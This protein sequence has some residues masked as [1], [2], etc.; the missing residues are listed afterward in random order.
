MPDIAGLGTQALLITFA[1]AAIV[2]ALFGTQMAR[3][4]DILADRTGLGEALVGAVLLGAGT[5]ISG[6]V[7]SISTA[8]NGAPELAASNALGGI[9][10]QTMFLALADVFYRKVNL[11][12]AAASAV[13]LGQATILII[14]TVLPIMAVMTPEFSIWAIHPV[15]PVL[16]AVY[17]IGLHNAHRIKLEPMWQPRQTEH[18]R[19]EDEEEEQDARSTFMLASSFGGLLL[20]VGICGYVVGESGLELSGRLG[21]SQG[22]VG[23]LGT[24]VV[25]SL[26]E[27]VTTIAA[28]R[29]GALQLAIGGIIGGNMFDALF[30]SASD[31][32]YREG[33]LYHALSDRVVFWMAL[34]GLMTAILLMG[35]LRRERQ[36]PAGIGWESVLLISL[37]LGAATM[38]IA[39]G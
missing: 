27:L 33:S 34:V 14:L 12:H 7:T 5:S 22:V 8:A 35:L 36:G 24:A 2:I 32:A 11:E 18:T 15:S 39:L 3:I 6:I 17:L 37:W 16:V 9:A 20:V 23:A 25:T 19:C 1:G 28:V 29:Q 26:P 30:L 21:I 38:Q 10:A 13:N 31:I 4:A